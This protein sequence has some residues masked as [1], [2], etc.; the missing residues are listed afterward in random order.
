MRTHR[1]AI[2]AIILIT[3]CSALAPAA[4]LAAQGGLDRAALWHDDHDTLYRTPLGPVTVGTPVTLRFRA[5]AGGADAVTLRVWDAL[6]ESEVLLPMHV[7]AATPDGYDVWEAVFDTSN[8]PGLYWYRFGVQGGGERVTYEDDTRPGEG[9]YYPANEGGSGQVYDVSPDLSFQ[10]T[11]YDP[12]YTTPQ[13]MRDAVVYQIFPDRFRNGDPTNDPADG[14]VTFY[15][16]NPVI[17]HETW[18]EPPVDP[19]QPGPTEGAWGLDFFGGD[20]AGVIEKLDYLE[21]L[22]VTAIYFNP[23][24]AARSNHRYDTADYKAVDPFLGDMQTFETLVDEAAARGIA[25]I[26]DG[27]F[28][29]VSSDSPYFDR[30][31][32]YADEGACESVSSPTRGWFFFVPPKGAQPAACV[33]NPSGATFY[34]SW[35]GFDTIPKINNAA[36]GPRLL[37]YLGRNSVVNTWGRAGALGWRLDVGGD[38]DP[39]GPANDFWEQFRV[40]AHNAN[41]DT[42]IIGEEWGNATRWLLG[43]EWDSVMNYRLRTGILGFVRDEPFTDNDANG[44]RIIYALTPSELDRLIHDI[45]SD[46]PSMALAAMLNVLDS[47]DTSRL[48]FVAG[49]DARQR[50]AALLQFALPGAP[51]VYYGDEI[52]LDA[53]SVDD[54]GTFQDD[55]YNRAPYPWPD[56]SGDFYGPPD[57]A[58]LAFYQTLAATRH[59]TPALRS[60]DL[61]TLLTDDAAGVYAFLRVDAA[62]GSAALVALNKSATAQTASVDVAGLLPDGLTLAPTLGGDPLTTGAGPLEFTLGPLSGEIWTVATGA[63]FAAPEPPANLAAQGERGAVRLTWDAD[64]S[65]AGALVYRSPVAEGGF[66]PIT[67]DPVQDASY[68]DE[69]AANG[70]RFYYAVA[71]VGADGL[72]GPLSASAAAIPSAPITDA[73][74]LMDEAPTSVT[75]GYGVTA[76]VRAAVRVEGETE[77]EGAAP[78]VRA[79]AALIPAGSDPA[80]AAWQ[81]MTYAGEQDGADV[82]EGALPLT[83]AGDF[84]VMARFSS[85]AGASWTLAALPDGGQPALTVLPAEDVEAPEPPASASILQASLAGV[86]VQWEPSPSD[87]VRAYRVYRSTEDEPLSLVAEVAADAE[88]QVEDRAVAAGGSYR[89]EVRA[90]DAALNESAGAATDEATVQQRGIPVTFT[91]TVPDYTAQSD[92]PVYL[93]GDLGSDALPFW[94][95]AGVEMTKLDDRTWTVT[96]EIPEGAKIQYKYARGSWDAVEKGSECEEIANRM[97]TVAPPAGQDTLL[98]EDLVAKWRDLDKCG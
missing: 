48:G 73:F 59:A 78:G 94:D 36:N 22:G 51:T 10:L 23:I 13:W 25:I 8:G 37:F 74:Y 49:S 84:E 88:H 91:V 14:S 86:V 32:R 50:L 21:E 76:Q 47:H 54:N 34:V 30:Y 83:E 33:E 41:P 20:L 39:G 35:A 87:D 92:L 80:D 90:V 43:K 44:D 69:T 11:V 15:D 52:G 4:P 57:E 77:A 29:H 27:V 96:V 66:E 5:A 75:L 97:L 93:A 56:A 63:P 85:S 18:N 17:F 28:N 46:Y 72:I 3:T 38:I 65:A 42:V 82:Y 64:P 95:P 45:A 26:L 71:A 6:A 89:Y 68:T 62:S 7:V 67:A 98:V 81:P 79:E 16:D 12:A 2:L 31:H 61:I 55:P 1:Y 53:P 40:A 19:R 9:A 70:F 60:G 58:M 24:F